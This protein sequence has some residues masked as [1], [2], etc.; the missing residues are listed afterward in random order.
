[1]HMQKAILVILPRKKPGNSADCRRHDA[2]SGSP[3]LYAALPRTYRGMCSDISFAAKAGLPCCELDWQKL[4]SLN[5][6]QHHNQDEKRGIRSGLRLFELLVAHPKLVHGAMRG[7]R[8]TLE[9]ASEELRIN[10]QHCCQILP[11]FFSCKVGK[12]CSD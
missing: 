1:M 5:R 6:S 4:E 10:P 8:A 9:N 3:A 11:C 2:A 12:S 7:P